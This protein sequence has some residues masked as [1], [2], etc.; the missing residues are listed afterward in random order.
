MSY[1][2]EIINVSFNSNH[3]Q[4]NKK[5]EH[6]AKGKCDVKI[7]MNDNNTEKHCMKKLQCTK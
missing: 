1:K 4:S 7:K 5:Q 3:I 6:G 2:N